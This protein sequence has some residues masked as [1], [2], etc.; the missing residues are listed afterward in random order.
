MIS[1][2]I[3][4]SSCLSLAAILMLS[5]RGNLERELEKAMNIFEIELGWTERGL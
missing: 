5:G 2:W 4:R 1:V 3:T